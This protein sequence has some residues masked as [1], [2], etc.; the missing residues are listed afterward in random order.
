MTPLVKD[1]F[2]NSDEKKL[3]GM[4]PNSS[5][6]IITSKDK[7]SREDDEVCKFCAGPIIAFEETTGDVYCEKCIFEGRA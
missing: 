4:S 2:K 1:L 6:R 5:F 3:L 7:L